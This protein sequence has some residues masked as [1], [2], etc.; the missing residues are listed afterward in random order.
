MK[1]RHLAILISI[2][3]IFTNCKKD[4]ESPANILLSKTWKRGLVD[5]NPATNPPGPIIYYAVRNCEKDDSFKFGSENKLTWHRNI[6]KC[7]QNESPTETQTYSLN[8]TTNE[9]FINGTK[10]TLA[11]ESKSQIKYFALI[12]TTTGFQYLVY[13]LQ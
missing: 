5:K 2:L 12:P 13:L 11:E 9:L 10:F 7:D 4:S 1:I 3:L 8:R 6:D